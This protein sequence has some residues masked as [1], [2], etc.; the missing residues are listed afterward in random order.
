PRPATPF[1][2][3][4]LQL[5]AHVLVTRPEAR[6]RPDVLTERE[7]VV[8]RYL[9][10]SLTYP[11]IAEALYVSRNTVKTHARNVIR[12]LHATSRRD[13]VARARLLHYL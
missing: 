9:A 10:T 3:H 2:E 1:V 8:L 5:P 11:E 4:M 13:A 7:R 12:K 6:H